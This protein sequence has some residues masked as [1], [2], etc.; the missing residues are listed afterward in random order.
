MGVND[1]PSAGGADPGARRPGVAPTANRFELL[2][3]SVTDYAIYLID[4][5]GV[6]ASWNA[7][8]ERFKGYAPAAIIGRHFSVFFSDE[9][10]ASGLPSRAMATAER[11]GRFESEGWRVRQDGSRFWASVVIDPVRDSSGQLVGFATITRD[12]TERR[13]TEEALRQSEERFRLL[14]ESV[15]D[16]AIYLI[17]PGGI[18][19][20]WNAGAARAKGY[21]ATEILGQHFSRFYTDE[22]RAN[23][24][25]ERALRVAL[26]EGRFEAEGWRVRRDGTRFWANVVIHPVRDSSGRHIGFAKVTRDLTE[27]REAQR[28]LERAQEAFFQAQKMDAIGKLTGGV[29]HD[30][31]N[32]LSAI[33]GSLDLGR[34]RLAQGKDISR[35]IDNALQ[36]A[37]RGAT[38]TQRMLAFARKQQ[39]RM[40]TIDLPTL[41]AGMA[42]LLQRTIGA[43]ITVETRFPPV[44]RPIRG[45]PAQL[46]LAILNLAVNARDAMPDGGRIVLEA[47][48]ERVVSGNGRLEP[49]DY[50]RLRMIDTGEGMDADTLAHAMEPFFTTKG[51]GKGT[52]L[53]LSMVHGFADQ[54]GGGLELESTPGVGTT[55][56]MWLPVATSHAARNEGEPSDVPAASTADAMTIL[57]VDDDQLVLTNV[58]AMLEDMGHRVVQAASG[59]EA[60]ERLASDDIDLVITDYAMPGMT[61][62]Q[63]IDAARARRPSLPV[64]LVSGYAD[65]DGRPPTNIA[66]LAKPF[67]AAELQRVI[68]E[69]A[70]PPAAAA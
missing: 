49:G 21:P 45:D 54:C 63:L 65:F 7:G 23:G 20:S 33:V 64:V 1:E 28:T 66:R 40:E 18:V 35:F 4:P 39:L 26:A 56:T 43:G 59:A 12:L 48:E 30:F 2:V 16:Y 42:D 25:P 29:A 55:V 34:R 57:A 27:R 19:T 10:R 32:L 58:V 60:L 36:A 11:E 3:Q 9:D 31:N 52:G 62:L 61:G 69:A 70:A 68:A 44:L 17:D 50:V 6:V 8:A 24:M 13:A 22:D 46:E 5:A 15:T 37:E 41:I 14:V 67:F 47:G 53:G 51:V 38:L